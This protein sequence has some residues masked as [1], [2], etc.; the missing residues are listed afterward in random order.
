MIVS[1]NNR[2]DDEEVTDD[3]LTPYN[4]YTYLK[5]MQEFTDSG[6]ELLVIDHEELHN[7]T[8]LSTS[9][10]DLPK[11]EEFP[12]P[13]LTQAGKYMNCLLKER[14]EYIQVEFNMLSDA[15]TSEE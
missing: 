2:L 4:R 3:L 5:S 15:L 9:E 11:V 1:F 8:H 10:K 14:K 13:I 6:S 7:P 12:V